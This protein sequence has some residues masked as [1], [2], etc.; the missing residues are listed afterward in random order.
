M[1]PD[2]ASWRDVV[3]RGRRCDR[4]VAPIGAERPHHGAHR[5]QR[6]GA[7]SFDRRQRVRGHVGARGGRSAASTA[8]D[9]CQRSAEHQ[10]TSHASQGSRR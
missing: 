7:G 5:T 9:V 3:E 10:P 4:R 6:V 2:V 1:L 8:G